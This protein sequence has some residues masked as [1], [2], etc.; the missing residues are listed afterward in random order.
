MN[1]IIPYMYV[2]I[3]D[4]YEIILICMHDTPY[5]NDDVTYMYEYHEYV[6]LP[7]CM[8]RGKHTYP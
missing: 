3:P 4:M 5:I 6:C 8:E 2:I 7:R 1:D